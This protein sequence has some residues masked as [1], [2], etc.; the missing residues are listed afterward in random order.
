[1]SL[2]QSHKCF[3]HA[4]QF[5]FRTLIMIS[6]VCAC[7]ACKIEYRLIIQR[8]NEPVSLEFSGFNQYFIDPCRES[9]FFYPLLCMG[10][11]GQCQK[12]NSSPGAGGDLLSTNPMTRPK[13]TCGCLSL[14]TLWLSYSVYGS[15]QSQLV[16]TFKNAHKFLFLY[17]FG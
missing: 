10:V 2:P 12:Q 11:K 15:A 4:S 5:G 7:S 14:Q 1:M 9:V 13:S 16:P 3:Q 17:K 6:T 8:L